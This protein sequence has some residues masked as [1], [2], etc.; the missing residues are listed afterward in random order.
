MWGPLSPPHGLRLG[1]CLIGGQATVPSF[2]INLYTPCPLLPS[3]VK[4]V[5]KTLV[6]Q[7]Q[8]RSCVPGTILSIIPC[9]PWDGCYLL[10]R[11]AKQAPMSHGLSHTA[12]QWSG[13]ESRSD[14]RA[15]LLPCRI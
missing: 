13:F 1:V 3:M 9:G 15:W 10:P 6:T 8:Q 12:M 14:F 7:E 2:Q 4:F 5:Y 11:M